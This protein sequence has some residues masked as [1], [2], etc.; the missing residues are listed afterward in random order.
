M[1]EFIEAAMRI[2][3]SSVCNVMLACDGK[4]LRKTSQEETI[5]ILKYII[6]IALGEHCN[7]LTFM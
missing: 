3:G 2:S 5:L 7:Y 1:S 6:K 4:S